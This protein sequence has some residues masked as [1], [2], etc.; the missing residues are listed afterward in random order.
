MKPIVTLT[1]NPALDISLAVERVENKTRSAVGAGDSFVGALVLQLADDRPPE[2]AY[3][4]ALAAGA[5]ALMT[6]ATELCRPRD[7]EHLYRQLAGQE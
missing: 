6:P 7:V 5:A 4:Y 1:M 2:E 3:R